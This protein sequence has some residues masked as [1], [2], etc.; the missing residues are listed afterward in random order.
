[1]INPGDLRVVSMNPSKRDQTMKYLLELPFVGTTLYNLIHCRLNFNNLFSNSK[2]SNSM[3]YYI[4]QFYHNAHFEN[5]NARYPFASYI[6]NYLN[7][8]IRETLKDSNIS[9]YIISG[10]SRETDFNLIHKQ[11]TDYNPSIECEIVH[12]S[13]DFPHLEN[14]FATY[15]LIKLYLLD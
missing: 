14:P 9:I 10:E 11:Y 5:A 2:G 7:L 15:D 8:D 1:M 6:T 4:D 12:K 3:S 13:S